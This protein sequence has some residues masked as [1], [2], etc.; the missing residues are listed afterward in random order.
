MPRTF[1]AIATTTVTIKIMQ[2]FHVYTYKKEIDNVTK[3]YIWNWDALK[4]Y[5]IATTTTRN[6]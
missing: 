6:M 1:Y 5:V 3:N 4:F 2:K